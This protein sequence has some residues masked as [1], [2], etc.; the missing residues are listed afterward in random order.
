MINRKIKSYIDDLKHILDEF[1]YKD[2]NIF[3]D[4]IRQ[5][6][7]KNQQIFIFG[8]GGSAATAS[9]FACDINKGV[10]LNLKKRFKVICLNDNIP[11]I[12]AY[13]NDISYEDIFVEQLKNFLKKDDLVIAISASGNSKNVLKAIEFANKEGGITFGLTGYD[14]GKLSKL[15][16]YSLI[17]SSCDMQKIEELHLIILHMLMQTLLATL[18]DKN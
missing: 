12:M 17:V 4:L 1:P 2:F 16:K 13:A 8:N 18:K 9:H 6:Y 14:G 15:A 3:L 7:N 11:T 5:A 10:S